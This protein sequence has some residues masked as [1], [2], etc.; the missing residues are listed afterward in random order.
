MAEN[1]SFVIF[2]SFFCLRVA[3][4]QIILLIGL[5]LVNLDDYVCKYI[6]AFSFFWTMTTKPKLF[7]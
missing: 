4:V 1:Y 2:L 7:H 5:F 6:L 3:F